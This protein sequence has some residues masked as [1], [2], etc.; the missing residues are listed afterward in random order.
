MRVDG[1]VNGRSAGSVFIN[2]DGEAYQAAEYGQELFHSS[3]LDGRVVCTRCDTCGE[4]K[5]NRFCGNV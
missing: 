1:G 2:D 4:V 3:R 5:V